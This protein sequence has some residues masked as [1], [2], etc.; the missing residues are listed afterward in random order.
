[1]KKALVIRLGAI[2]DCI[3]I[4]PLLKLLKQDGFHVTV[5]TKKTGMEVLKCNPN[6]DKLILFPD[7]ENADTFF[8]KIEGQYDKVVNLSGSIEGDIARITKGNEHHLKSREAIRKACDVNYYD[9]TNKKGG[10][11]TTGLT[12]ELYFSPLEHSEAK[13]FIKKFK[14]RFVI[15]WSLAGS[16]YHKTYPY[17]EYVARA[18]LQY[19]NIVILTIG[20]AIAQLLEWNLPNTKN[21]ADKWSLRKSMIMTKYVDL[22]IGP[23]TGILHAAGCF[24]TKKILLL[25]AVSENNIAEHWKN[26]KVLS[27]PVP[28]NPCFRIVYNR[29]GCPLEPGLNSPVCMSG[30]PAK[31]VFNAIEEVYKQWR[32]K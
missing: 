13:R 21:Y 32:S 5:Y 14:G 16:S 22:V 19:P 18:L 11:E 7:K 3:V 20:D 25:S 29:D 10:Y 31:L 12:G 6:I 24:D 8:P 30:L 23:D 26:K 4:T 27:A 1:M 9:H 15:L 28:C 2:G 17:S